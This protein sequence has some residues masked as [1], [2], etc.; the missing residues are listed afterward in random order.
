MSRH[1]YIGRLYDSPPFA[2]KFRGAVPSTVVNRRLGG[3]QLSGVVIAKEGRQEKI[4]KGDKDRTLE[5]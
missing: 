2:L 3:C 1:I 4:E 5:H